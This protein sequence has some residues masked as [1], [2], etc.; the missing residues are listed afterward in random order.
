MLFYI[1]N[2]Q[3]VSF[4]Q[5]HSL[6][7]KDSNSRANLETTGKNEESLRDFFPSILYHGIQ[8]EVIFLEQNKKPAR[9]CHFPGNQYLILANYVNHLKQISVNAK[10]HLSSP[11]QANALKHQQLM[12]E[13]ICFKYSLSS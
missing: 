1:V 13:M 9:N 5:E 4:E 8:K 3:N 11:C 10:P 12:Y 2:G 6:A 7:S